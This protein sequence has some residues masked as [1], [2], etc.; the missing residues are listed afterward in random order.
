MIAVGVPTGPMPRTT[1]LGHCDNE[2]NFVY[3]I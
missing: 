3:G 1:E 2:I